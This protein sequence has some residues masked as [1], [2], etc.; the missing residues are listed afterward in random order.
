MSDIKLEYK[1]YGL[2]A[3]QLSSIQKGIQFMH[4]STRYGIRF[5]G[6]NSQYNNWGFYNESVVLLCGGTT[7]K[8]PERLGTL[9]KYLN[10]LEHMNVLVAEFT[11]EDLGD[12]LTAFA[13]LVDERVYERV[14]YPDFVFENEK[15]LDR[16]MPIFANENE[17]KRWLEWVDTIGGIQNNMLREFLRPLELAQ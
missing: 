4:A 2:C 1:M 5:G 15:Q 7:N 12:Q 11:E 17:N 10:Q 6:E 14:K 3:Y 13:F 8:S 16:L 9:N